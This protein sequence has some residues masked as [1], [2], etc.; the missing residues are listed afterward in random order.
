MPRRAAATK[1]VGIEDVARAASVSITTVSHALSGRGRVAPATQDR[2]RRVADELGYV[3]NRLASALR[4]RRS[5]ILGFVSD[6][7]STAPV[8]MR[9]LLGA[10]D[11]AA[12]RGQLLVVV[13]G[14]AERAI[15]SR[16]MSRLLTAQIDAVVYARMVHQDASALPRELLGI[17]TALVDT[18]DEL[19]LIPSVAPDDEQIGRLATQTLLAAGHTRIAHLTVSV[20]GPGREGRRTGYTEAMTAAGLEPWVFVGGDPGMSAAGRAAFA[21]MRG[22][23]AR[24]VTA[25]FCFNDQMALG[26]YDSAIRAGMSIPDEL[27]VVSVGDFEPIAAALLP[28]LT[29]VSLPHYEMGRWG[30]R[31]ALALLDPTEPLD[32][33]LETRMPGAL[34]TR[35]SVSS[36]PALNLL[37]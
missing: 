14:T 10:Q 31:A 12:E 13:A 22:S 34:V 27:S 6:D 29:T 36:P 3:P 28:G 18:T 26:I 7:I 9:L 5:N 2:V 24:D 20:A 21:A 19:G 4:G 32:R 16:Q 17:P 35:Q 8:A 23:G 25:I 1:P 15:E 33:R 37:S 30:V 11:A